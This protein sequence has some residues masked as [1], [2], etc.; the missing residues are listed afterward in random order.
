M[1]VVRYF[2]EWKAELPW[3]ILKD[4]YGETKKGE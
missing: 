4:L 3:G 1:V 2:N